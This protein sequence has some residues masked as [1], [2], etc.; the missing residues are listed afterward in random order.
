MERAVQRL[1]IVF[2]V[3]T[4]GIWKAV[5]A[6]FLLKVP[7]VLIFIMTVLGASAGVST[8]YVFG[9][10]IT[11]YIKKKKDS[12]R[13]GHKQSRARN[14]F[15][16]YGIIGFALLGTILMGPQITMAMGLIIVK[17]QKKLFLWILA[18]IV[19]WTGVL[20]ILAAL[21]IELFTKLSLFPHLKGTS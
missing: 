14:L 17:T 6:G 20:T 15:E 2:L 8:I 21:G 13:I 19:A 5:P 7:P 18:G 9:K 16:K 1:I 10:W 12:R 4:I 11:S 3:G